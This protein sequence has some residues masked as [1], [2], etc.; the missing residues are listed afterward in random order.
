MAGGQMIK[1][2]TNVGY[3]L[4]NPTEIKTISINKA[5]QTIELTL[6]GGDFT[7]VIE[8]TPANIKILES[9]EQK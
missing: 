6:K 2:K 4:I 3:I 7:S 1:L 9:L 5:I 8:Y